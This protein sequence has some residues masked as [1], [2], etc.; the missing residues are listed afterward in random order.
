[1]LWPMKSALSPLTV[2]YYTTQTSWLGALATY[3][4]QSHWPSKR[5][6][7]LSGLRVVD[8]MRCHTNNCNVHR[9]HRRLAEG[10]CKSYISVISFVNRVHQIVS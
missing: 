8:P 6:V 3:L 4:L 9:K 1:M 7:V 5:S 10:R 2:S